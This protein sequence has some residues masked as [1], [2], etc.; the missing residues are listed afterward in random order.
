MKQDL[1]QLYE[2]NLNKVMEEIDAYRKEEDLWKKAGYI[3]N[4]AGHLCLHIEGNLKHFI[5]RLLGDT[6]YERKR[7]DE[8]SCDPVSKKRLLN[9]LEETKSVIRK[10]LSEMEQ[11]DL[12]KQYP[13]DVHGHPMSTNYFL[14][15]LLGHLN[16]HLGQINYLRRILN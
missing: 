11:A 7:N 4:S 14:T 9:G 13:I 10:T 8:F 1:V 5:G 16:Y 3:E 6:A 12:Q 2:K 15:H